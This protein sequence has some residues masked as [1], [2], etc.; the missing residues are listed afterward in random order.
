MALLGTVSALCAESYRA[1]NDSMAP[2]ALARLPEV[3]S[4]SGTPSGARGLLGIARGVALPTRFDG[5]GRQVG[6]TPPFDEIPPVVNPR[7][8]GPV[9]ERQ[10]GW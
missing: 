9:P 7:K 3:W 6:P 4:G 2:S 5:V 10:E 8:L 1:L